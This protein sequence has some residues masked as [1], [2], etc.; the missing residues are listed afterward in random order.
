MFAVPCADRQ[1][2]KV[3]LG[4]EQARSSTGSGAGLGTDW[5]P[6]RLFSPHQENVGYN[7][8]PNQAD[9]T[10]KGQGRSVQDIF[11]G[12][13]VSLD[14]LTFFAKELK[15]R[16]SAR[17]EKGRGAPITSFLFSSLDEK[18]CQDIPPVPKSEG[19]AAAPCLLAARPPTLSVR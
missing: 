11:S 15:R 13:A 8:Q 16:G 12:L 14:L 18:V 10:W 3:R 6:R 19:L 9:K 5:S 2:S 7:R 17:D 4:Q 1:G